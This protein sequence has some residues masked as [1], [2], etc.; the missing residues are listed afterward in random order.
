MI[1]DGVDSR[2]VKDSVWS[3]KNAKRRAKYNSDP[4]FREKRQREAKAWRELNYEKWKKQSLA[5][6]HKHRPR[7]IKAR[8]AKR[9]GIS[10][11]LYESL[12]E[13]HKGC[14]AIC[15]N[16]CATRRSLAVDHDHSTGQI[17]GLLC[18]K[19]NHGIGLFHDNP[20]RLREAA[21]Y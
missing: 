13:L 6:Y 4:I 16:V 20:K 12:L 3:D 1:V 7:I 8:A 11:E 18:Q 15:G 14:C 5:N 21:E 17:R 2:I 10:I 9:H 19:C